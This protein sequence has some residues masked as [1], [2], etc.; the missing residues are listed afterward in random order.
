V[1]DNGRLLS[2]NS[3]PHKE[4]IV[5]GTL[6]EVKAQVEKNLLQMQ[7]VIK[8]S[9]DGDTV[10]IRGTSPANEKFVL[11]LKRVKAEKDEGERTAMRIEWEKDPDEMFWGVLVKAVINPASV[12]MPGMP[13]QNGMPVQQYGGAGQPYNMPVQQYGGAGQPYNMPVQ[14][15]GGANQ[16]YNMPVQQNG[17]AGQPYNM[18]VQQYNGAGQPYNMAV[19]QY[20]GAGQPYNMPVQQYGGANQQ[21]QQ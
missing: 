2:G 6:T 15:Y 13:Q 12:G 20:G 4:Q 1:A 16:P 19:Q 9:K 8:S 21:Y 18:P 11:V 17:G 7:L 14:Q 5:T 10:R 3:G